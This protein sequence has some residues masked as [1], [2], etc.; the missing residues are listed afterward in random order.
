MNNCFD[1]NKNVQKPNKIKHCLNIISN[2]HSNFLIFL[3]NSLE[4][5]IKKS[6]K[7]AI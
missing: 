1:L 4:V 3:I 6:D 5:L 7:N 2:T